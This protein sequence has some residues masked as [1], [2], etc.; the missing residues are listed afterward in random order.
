M[1]T[2][3]PAPPKATPRQRACARGARPI[4]PDALLGRDS[5][6]RERRFEP[7]EL[8]ADGFARRHARLRRRLQRTPREPDGHAALQ[9]EERGTHTHE[10]VARIGRD[11]MALVEHRAAHRQRRRIAR[12]QADQVEIVAALDAR[13]VVRDREDGGRRSV[14]VIECRRRDET[15][16]PQIRDPR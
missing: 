14:V 13:C 9:A 4:A 10:P 6:F 16:A 3:S 8:L 15:L 2:A 12:A 1:T 7:G 5:L 11:P